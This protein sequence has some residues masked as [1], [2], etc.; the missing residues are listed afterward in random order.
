M[1]SDLIKT[2]VQ[3][4]NSVFKFRC[5][6]FSTLSGHRRMRWVFFFKRYEPKRLISGS[7]DMGFRKWHNEGSGML[8]LRGIDFICLIV[9]HEIIMQHPDTKKCF[10]ELCVFRLY[11]CC[12]EVYN[13]ASLFCAHSA[14]FQNRQ[15]TGP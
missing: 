6:W 11:F 8:R 3:K 2:A 13:C 7:V 1:Y 15:A 5:K 9:C 4:L 14:H 10:K 12:I